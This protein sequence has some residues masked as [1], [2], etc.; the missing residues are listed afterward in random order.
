ML[1]TPAGFR[2]SLT[3][4]A[5][6]VYFW[7]RAEIAH[8]A[9]HPPNRWLERLG[10]ASY[11]LYLTHTLAA[12]LFVGSVAGM[13]AGGG[14]WVIF[15]ARLAFILAIMTAFYLLVE[16]PAHALAKR[17]KVSPEPAKR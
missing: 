2:W 5:G 10:Q 11:S 12:G 16:A 3:V 8:S 6:Y 7:L 1:H 15:A 4:F 14:P 13:F 17:L 9:I